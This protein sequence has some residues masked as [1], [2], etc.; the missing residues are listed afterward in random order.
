MKVTTIKSDTILLFLMIAIA[1]AFVILFNGC[2]Y[3]GLRIYDGT[4]H[5][6]NICITY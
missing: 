5:R 6:E 3:R 4:V 1:I 2:C